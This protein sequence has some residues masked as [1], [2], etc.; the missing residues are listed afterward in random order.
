MRGWREPILA[1]ALIALAL[2][3]GVAM[4]VDA[5]WTS[6]LASAVATGIVWVSLAVGVV[7]AFGRSRPIGLFRF[8]AVDLLYGVVLGVLLR[9]V[10]GWAEAAENGAAV[11]PSIALIDGQAS[12]SWWGVEVIGALAVAPVLEELFFRGV[13]LVG[14]YTLLRRPFGRV[15]AAASAVLT[16]SALF[17]LVHALAQGADLSATLSLF[18]L[19]VACAALVV[20]TGRI[21]GAVLVHLLFNAT[22][23]ALAAV[24]TAFG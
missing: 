5:L 12:T 24:G 16:S 23:L 1:V 8:R 10:Q 15:V 19:G 7:F 17:V 4:L 18:L 13:I 2:G 11:F 22:F 14:I 3:L 21:W 6:P 20:L 9:T